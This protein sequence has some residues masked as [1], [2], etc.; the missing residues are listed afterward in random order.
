MPGPVLATDDSADLEDELVLVVD[1]A[2]KGIITGSP[3]LP[4][5]SVSKSW[6]SSADA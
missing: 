2:G 6:S 4:S 1:L 3:T 5:M